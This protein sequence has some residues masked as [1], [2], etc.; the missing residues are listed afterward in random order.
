MGKK[1]S[2]K[3]KS[4]IAP[5]ST[6][7][8]RSSAI[9]L[10]LPSSS[11]GALG[12]TAPVWKTL[13]FAMQPQQQ[14]EW[15]WAAVSVSVSFYY[16]SASTWTQC[17]LAN[18]ELGQTTCCLNGST[19]A[20]NQPWYLDRALTR[21]SHLKAF[22]PGSILV[23][24]VKAEID[25]DRPLGVRIGWSNGG[26]H[27]VVIDGYSNSDL[28]D[29]QDPFWGSSTIDYTLFLSSYQ[30]SGSWTHSYWTQP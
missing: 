20:C 6:S 12:G 8:L 18:D 27:F 29:I 23:A 9:P 5:K 1:V 22:A 24:K 26:G 14:T 10:G 11:P 16:S 4:V 25:A 17:S 19:V 15:C 3:A 28:L 2:G 30:G 13:P 7:V 21:T